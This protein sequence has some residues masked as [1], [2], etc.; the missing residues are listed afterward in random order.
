M[1]TPPEV[2]VEDAGTVTVRSEVAVIPPDAAMICV[3]PGPTAVARPVELLSAGANG[4][5]VLSRECMQA[6]LDFAK[7]Q[8]RL[9]EV[10]KIG[11]AAENSL[12]A[13]FTE[14]L[15]IALRQKGGETKYIAWRRLAHDR[16]W[17]ERFGPRVVNT[18]VENLIKSGTLEPYTYVE[19]GED[20][21][22]RIK[23]N[24]NRVKLRQWKELGK[25]Q[26]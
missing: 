14:S 5:K 12:E 8:E 19:E 6:A 26:K 16:K 2:E 24:N 10:F 23:T 9:R 3:M 17:E 13:Q 11:V 4:D 18:T 20:G 25:E 15:K 7:W 1:L 21:K 22:K